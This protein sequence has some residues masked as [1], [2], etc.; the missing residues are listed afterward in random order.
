MSSKK[1]SP[2]EDKKQIEEVTKQVQEVY[3]KLSDEPEPSS[4]TFDF[5]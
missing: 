2:E 1:G 4:F 3:Q 5:S